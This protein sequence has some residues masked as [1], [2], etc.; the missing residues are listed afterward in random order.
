MSS[1]NTIPVEWPE[2]GSYV[3]DAERTVADRWRHFGTIGFDAY[4]SWVIE[5]EL[6]RAGEC[7]ARDA[8][9]RWQ[10]PVDQSDQV[11]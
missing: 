5:A 4:L 11:A 7:P 2:D 9:L 3:H 8:L 1:V 6:G 10:D